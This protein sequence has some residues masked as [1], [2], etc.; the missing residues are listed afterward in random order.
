MCSQTEDAETLC[1]RVQLLTL[2]TPFSS[3]LTP[4]SFQPFP[5]WQPG[6]SPAWLPL[7]PSTGSSSSSAPHHAPECLPNTPHHQLVL[8]C[9]PSQGCCQPLWPP[10]KM[11]LGCYSW[12]HLFFPW[13]VAA[14]MR[15]GTQNPTKRLHLFCMQRILE[16]K[17]MRF[18]EEKN[19]NTSDMKN[20]FQVLIRIIFKFLVTE[21]WRKAR[22]YSRQKELTRN[23]APNFSFYRKMKDLVTNIT[24]SFGCVRLNRFVSAAERLP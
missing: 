18:K 9:S 24:N 5:G 17:S 19:L 20:L 22:L 10:L 7:G 13:A 11:L 8:L 23:Q 3:P 2:C 16:Q 15:K 14:L 1:A 21:T 6:L 12:T 4:C